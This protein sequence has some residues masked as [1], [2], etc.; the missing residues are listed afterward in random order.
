M[1]PKIG[2]PSKAALLRHQR[3]FSI[4][5]PHEWIVGSDLWVPSA[6]EEVVFDKGR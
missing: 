6:D 3:Q 5:E 4:V 2:K 1:P